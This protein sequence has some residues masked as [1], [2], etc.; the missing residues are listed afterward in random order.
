LI[1]PPLPIQLD[2]NLPFCWEIIQLKAN[3]NP[4]K[5]AIKHEKQTITNLE[6]ELA[7]NQVAN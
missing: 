4:D 3:T 5:V 1:T 2:K 7:S 6:L